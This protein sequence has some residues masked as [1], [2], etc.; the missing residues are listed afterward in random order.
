M[1]TE[2]GDQKLLGN[3]RKLI[4]LVSADANY[5]PANADITKAALA[6]HYTAARGALDDVAPKNAPSKSAINDRQ[7][8]FDSLSGLMRRSFAM[9]KASGASKGKLEDAQTFLRK[10]TGARKSPRIKDN[11]AT[12]E[13]EGEKQHSTS[14]MSFENRVGNVAAF[15]SI[16]ANSVSYNPNE[17]ELKISSLQALVEAEILLPRRY[18]AE[19]QYEFRHALLQLMAYESMLQVERRTTRPGIGH[20]L[21]P[22]FNTISR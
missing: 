4:D 22:S 3:Y 12:P 7:E 6:T 11:P 10:I 16:L 21:I 5:N 8:A 2:S 20:S 14:Q 18:G 15:V 17:N 13:V 19:I 1:P 9:L